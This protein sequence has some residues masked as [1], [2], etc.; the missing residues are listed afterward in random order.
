MA[1]ILGHALYIKE[2][3]VGQ[4]GILKKNIKKQEKALRDMSTSTL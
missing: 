2:G 3:T 4:L 1:V